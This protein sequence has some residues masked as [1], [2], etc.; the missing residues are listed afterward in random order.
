M[1]IAS[2][3]VAH[4]F[5]F[6][7]IYVDGVR[8]REDIELKP[9]QIVRLHTRGKRFRVPERLRDSL[10]LNDD[11]FAAIDKPAGLPVHPTVDNFVENAKFQLEKELD[12]KLYTTHRLD[13]PTRGVLVFAKSPD[14]QRLFNKILA[15]RQIEKIY[16]A[17]AE[18]PLTLGLKTH[19][20]DP[21][22]RVP[23]TIESAP[24]EGWWKCDLEI[25]SVEDSN[26]Y[27]KHR[28]R[29][30]TGKTHQ[31]RA[32]FAALGAPLLGDRLYGSTAPFPLK[33]PQPESIALAC[34]ELKF[35]FRTRSIDLRRPQGNIEL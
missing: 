18:R 10:I 11:D 9:D 25:L 27:F 32:Q 20:I 16:E 4:W 17:T 34:E 19:Y 22:T 24:R 31:I 29:L 12:R 21:D 15:K 28:I 26:G 35:R 6:G 5:E 23:R 3:D 7:C 13:I 1:E 30:L 33:N 2:V 8:T 14:A